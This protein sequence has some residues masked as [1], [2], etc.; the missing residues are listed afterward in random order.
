MPDKISAVIIAVFFPPLAV[1]MTR[2][3]VREFWFNVALTGL[4]FYPGLIHAAALIERG[5]PA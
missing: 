4:G 5:R 3:F 2:G 1:L